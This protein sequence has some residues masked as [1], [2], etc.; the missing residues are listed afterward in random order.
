VISRM[1]KAQRWILIAVAAGVLGASTA[2]TLL[3]GSPAATV[4]PTSAG[5]PI[6]KLTA[7]DGQRVGI[8]ES[9]TVH[10]PRLSA[11]TRPTIGPDRQA[12]IPAALE[13]RR[14]AISKR[15]AD[16]MT[17]NGAQKKSIGTGHTWIDP[18]RV[19][20][21]ACELQLQESEAFGLSSDFR[22]AR[23]AALGLDLQIDRCVK[24]AGAANAVGA[25][26]VVFDG[27][28]TSGLAAIGAGPG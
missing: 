3:G 13:A 15:V 7:T 14:Q 25:S 18:G 26:R 8:D 6:E 5:P 1:T 12:R 16:C 10:L 4:E 2:V 20:E 21:R 22:V 27:C 28:V 11:A 9:G 19:A 17:S 23:L 24:R